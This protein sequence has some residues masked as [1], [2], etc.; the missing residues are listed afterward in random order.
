MKLSKRIVLF[1]IAT[2]FVSFN[3][4]FLLPDTAH[5]SDKPVVFG[6][7]LDRQQ[8]IEY[9]NK[10]LEVKSIE[11]ETVTKELDVITDKKDNLASYVGSLKDHIASLSDMFVRINKYAPD[12]AGN[13]YAFGNCT[14]YV[15]S[16]RPDISNSLGNAN[17]WYINAKLSGWNVGSKPKKGAVAVSTAG[18]W[19]HVAYVEGVTPNG[20][21]VTISEMNA[22]GFNQIS[23]RTV[24]YSE[25][26]Y[27]YELD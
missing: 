12:S 19:G 23:S 17:T 11:V 26:N 10:L 22:P 27:I 5:A 14:Y 21:W 6:L 1:A 2:L 20:E 25:F 9:S 15:K 7:M 16:R 13:N 4:V 3:S 18:W 8:E 24:H